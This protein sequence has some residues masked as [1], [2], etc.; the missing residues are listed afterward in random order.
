MTYTYKKWQKN[1]LITQ[2]VLGFIGIVDSIYLTYQKITNNEVA[3]STFSGCNTVINSDYAYL[4][5][6]PL[7]YLGVIYYSTLLII[8]VL[9]LNNT[10]TYWLNLLMLVTFSGFLMSGYFV[11]L[12]L[13]EIGSICIYC[14]LS[15]VLSTLL[16]IF[17]QLIYWS[18]KKA[19]T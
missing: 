15:A 12:Q 4:I 1:L 14:M 13:F 3:C 19:A 16:F 17:T 7:A 2:I 10:K 5:G 18:T 6:I 9:V 8:L 11:Y